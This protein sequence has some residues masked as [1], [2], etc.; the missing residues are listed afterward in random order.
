[1][2]LRSKAYFQMHIAT[3]L[4]G[5]TAILGKVISISEF[6]LVWYRVFF[7]SILM[8][9]F[10]GL[11][12]KVRQLS[13]RNLIN[14]SGIG[15]LL[16]AHWVLWY[17]SIKYANASVAVSCIACISLFISILEPILY[18][19]P[20]DTSNLMLS[21]IVIP[22]ILLINQS[23]DLHYRLG[24]ILGIIAAFMAALFTIFNKKYVQEIDANTITFVQMLSGFIFLSFCLPIYIHFSPEGFHLPNFQDIVL[25]LILAVFCTVIPYNL[26]LKTLKVTDAF[27]TSLINNLEPVYGIILAAILLGES[28]ELNWKFYLGTLI[29]LLAVFLHAFMTHQQQ[30]KGAKQPN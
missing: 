28:K 10:P 26:F 4:W 6:P 20:F 14:L 18:K 24:F 23:L 15:I 17:G 2:Q 13:K 25:L 9:F 5:I 29:I 12:Q 19:T 8:S 3:F 11:L 27:T 21:F 7:V 16:A 30:Q 1:M 22:G